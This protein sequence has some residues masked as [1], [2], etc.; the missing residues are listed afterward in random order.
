MRPGARSPWGGGGSFQLQ[1]QPEPDDPSQPTEGAE[2][3][4]HAFRPV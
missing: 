4:F 1:Q 3:L 2:Q